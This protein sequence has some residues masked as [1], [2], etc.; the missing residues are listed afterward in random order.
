MA[1]LF[2]S[3]IA[4]SSAQVEIYAD[5]ALVWLSDE[6]KPISNEVYKGTNGWSLTTKALF[7][8]GQLSPFVGLQAQMMNYNFPSSESKLDLFHLGFPL[9]VAYHLRPR[10]TSFNVMG[11][12]AYCPILLIN[13]P[14]RGITEDRKIAGNFHL[15]V[16]LT[17]DYLY[18]GGRW[19]FF[20]KGRLGTGEKMS[21]TSAL[22]LGVRF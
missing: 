6:V 9:G 3:S 10:S 17:L 8:Q 18:L 21:S 22:L 2:V 16:T 15:G 11:S 12:L 1:L 20:P 5:A 4:T 13:D 7:G 19:Q 14:G